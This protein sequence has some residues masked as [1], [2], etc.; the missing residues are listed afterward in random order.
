MKRML[1]RM[2]SVSAN[3]EMRQPLREALSGFA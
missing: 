1:T 2:R 3:K